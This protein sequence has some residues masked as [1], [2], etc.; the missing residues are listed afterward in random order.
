MTGFGLMT[1]SRENH[2]LLRTYLGFY[3]H[4]TLFGNW[5]CIKFWM[6]MQA[7]DARRRKISSVLF[8]LGL[9]SFVRGSFRLAINLRCDDLRLK[10]YDV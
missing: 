1:E 5:N 3:T 4:P 6:T 7:D 9:S 8:I 2:C 10:Y